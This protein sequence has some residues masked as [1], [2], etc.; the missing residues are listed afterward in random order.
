MSALFEI[1]LALGALLLV[2]LPLFR[3][4]RGEEFDDLSPLRP[5][6][7]ADKEVIMTALGEIEFDYRMNKLSEEDYKTLKNS[8]SGAAVEIIKAEEKSS[9]PVK[10]RKTKAKSKAT[11]PNTKAIEDEIEAELKAMDRDNR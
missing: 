4:M 9:V 8:Y 1:L 3:S 2:G 5:S 10:D 11:Q 7:A 6:L